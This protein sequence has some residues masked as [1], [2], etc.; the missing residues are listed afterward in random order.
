MHAPGREQ[1]I[2]GLNFF[3]NIYSVMDY[4]HQRIGLAKSKNYMKATAKTFLWWVRLTTLFAN[5][6]E[7][8]T[9][10]KNE[11]PEVL[12]GAAGVILVGLVA[13]G[14]IMNQKCKS[15]KKIE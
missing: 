4:E 8:F 9:T 2:L 14:I 11:Q 15:Q 12:Y 13:S 3:Q 7:N 10:L 6:G 1:W 5:Y